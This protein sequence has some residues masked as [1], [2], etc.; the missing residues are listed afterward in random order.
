MEHI[1]V[2]VRTA[3][4]NQML[5][6]SAK[7]WAIYGDKDDEKD[8]LDIQREIARLRTDELDLILVESFKTAPIPKIELHRQSLGKD[9]L[10][11]NDPNIIAIASDAAMDTDLTLLD[12]NDPAQIAR[13]IMTTLL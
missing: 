9:P 2:I 13:Y 1:G 5:V 10:Y 8:V 6:T 7:R 12:I 3:G 11:L 4:A